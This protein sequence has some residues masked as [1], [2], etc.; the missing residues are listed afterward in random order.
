M[1]AP[2]E[3][4]TD[5]ERQVLQLIGRLDLSAGELA[6]EIRALGYNH[7]VRFWALLDA[8]IDT[9]R[10]LAFDAAL[11]NRLRRLRQTRRRHSR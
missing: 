1:K 7:E 6:N 8:L 5:D 11:V 10:A 3:E 2:S 9:E 4:L